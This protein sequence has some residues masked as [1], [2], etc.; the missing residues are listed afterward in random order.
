MSFDLV[1]LEHA[2]AQHGGV[3]RVVVVETKG[4]TPRDVGAAMLIWKDGQSGT[5]GGG[6]LEFEA[7]ATARDNLERKTAWSAKTYALGPALSQ[8]CGGAVKL[9]YQWFDADH[10]P[11]R[12]PY[13]RPVMWSATMPIAVTRALEGDITVPLHVA[14]WFIEPL[15]EPQRQIWIYGAGHVGRA[16]VDVMAPLPDFAVT[17]VDTAPKRF[18]EHVP[19]GVTVLP[20]AKPEAAMRIAPA[21]AEHLILTYSHEI[22]L[23]LC[24]CALRQPFASVGLIGSA[25]KWTRFQKR[26]AELGHSANAIAQI[27]SPIGDPSLGKHPHAIAVGLAAALLAKPAETKMQWG[28]VGNKLRAAGPGDIE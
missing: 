13:A 1:G 7:T 14:D 2:V 19:Q 16:L 20:A 6:R 3:V 10:L 28:M 18:P 8:C 25:T 12:F 27:T 11:D 9:L 24:H 22:D 26:L 17:W 4:S 15:V 23:E 5:I 21:N